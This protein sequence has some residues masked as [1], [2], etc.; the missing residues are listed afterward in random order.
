MTITKLSGSF[1]C[2]QGESLDLASGL[3]IISLPNEG[4]KSTWTALLRTMLYGLDTRERRTKTNLPDKEHYRPWSGAPMEGRL[5]CLWRGRLLV[6]RRWDIGRTP[7]GG[8]E[9]LWQDTGEAVR[10]MTGENA[11]QLLTG[12]TR[13]VFDRSACLRQGQ[14]AVSQEAGL[15]QR[16]TALVTADDGGVPF[17]Q[18]E[19][20]LKKW[21]NSLQHNRTGQIPQ[22]ELEL[23]QLDSQIQQMGEVNLGIYKRQEQMNQLKDARARLQTAADRC[24]AGRDRLQWEKYCRAEDALRQAEQEEESV[25]QVA[26]RYRDPRTGELPRREELKG[27]REK[28]ARWREMAVATADVRHTLEQAGI[29]CDIPREA[30]TFP[31]VQKLRRAKTV[32]L[33]GA[34]LTVAAGVILAVADAGFWQG[35]VLPA[36]CIALALLAVLTLGGGCSAI[37]IA[38]RQLADETA[39]LTHE[40]DAAAAEAR[41]RLRQMEGQLRDLE[42]ARSRIQGEVLQALTPL[43]PSCTSMTE[44]ERE[45]DSLLTLLDRL[46]R[47]TGER[48][49]AK[50]LFDEVASQGR[51]SPDGGLPPEDIQ[52]QEQEIALRLAQTEETLHRL[53]LED[54]F[55]QGQRG[56]DPDALASHREALQEKIARLT[57]QR[58]A[59]DLALEVLEE[60]NSRL[61]ARFSPQLD[62]LAGEYLSRLTD[63]RYGKVTLNRAMEVRATP[64]EGMAPRE[65]LFL[66][67]G[68]AQQIWLSVRLA[69]SQ[70]LLPG[71]DAC[72]LILDETLAAFDDRRAEQAL[73][74]LHSLAEQRQILLFSCHGRE[75]AWAEQRED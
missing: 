7:M 10:G 34:I 29:S 67:Q 14:L 48:L 41:E 60:A 9:A 25:R 12:V 13:E 75:R 32:T 21:R 57:R 8:F 40:R 19:Q 18:A 1:G 39:R 2:L 49:H 43:V 51:G 17:G 62:Q 56:D 28:I 27:L 46:E 47:A 5:E 22:L 73:E 61:R 65:L 68:T 20:T 38:R 6:L 63:G 64:L 70:L 50:Q 52:E 66:S 16:L 71:T 33:V 59:I 53:E 26:E 3:N 54:S 72:P 42:E 24:R 37:L 55:A 35:R 58:D 69:I 45:I 23:S 36:A 31:L 44:A 30:P 4:G 74:L 11:G 15:E